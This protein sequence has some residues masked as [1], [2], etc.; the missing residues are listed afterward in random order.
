[1]NRMSGATGRAKALPAGFTRGQRG[2]VVVAILCLLLGAYAIGREAARR[3]WAPLYSGLA[4][5]DTSKI[6]DQ[7][8]AD[9]VKYQLTGGGNTIL[10]PQSQV[11]ELRV[12]LQGKNLPS[13][14]SDGYSTEPREPRPDGAGHGDPGGDR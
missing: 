5:E 4:G 7:L 14:T 3:T 1:M 9:G 13:S 10:V 6:V 11:Y 2:V 8:Q 12:Q